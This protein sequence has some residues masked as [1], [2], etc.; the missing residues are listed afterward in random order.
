[1]KFVSKIA[2]SLVVASSFM[3]VGCVNDANPNNKEVAKPMIEDTSIGFRK[4]DL[5]SENS[6]MPD[7]TQY[8]ESTP[9]S[10]KKFARA[11]QDAPPMIPHD[12]EGM[13]PI[14]INNN[15]C[16][17]CHAPG[18]AESMGA[19]PY[20]KSHLTDFRPKHTFD[21][22]KF[23]KAVDE[24]NNELAI[25]ELDQLS[26]ARFNCSGCHAPQ[27]DGQW[28]EKNFVAE[29]TSKD[30]SEKSNWVGTKLTEGLDT[31]KD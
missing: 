20:P 27:S 28:I 1:M 5:F 19:L 17:G 16:V 7:K 12:T 23:K 11:F 13:L 6:V 14:T 25:K 9:G 18:V 29:F 21:G 3:F 8:S 31:L 30:G 22:Q 26:G 15:Q 4:V 2:L 10:G 24:D